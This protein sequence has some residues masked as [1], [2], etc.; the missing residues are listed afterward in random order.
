MPINNLL[1]AILETAVNQLQRLDNS[2]QEK[3]KQLQGNVIGLCLK[4][5][6]LPLYFIISEQQID[7][8]N[9]YEGEADCFISVSIKAI[10][11][12]QDNQQ[13]TTLIKSGELEVVGDIQLVQQFASLMT[14]L[15][16]DWEELLSKKV[17]DPLAHKINHHFQQITQQGCQQLAHFKKQSALYLTEEIKVA[18]SALEVAHFCDQVSDLQ[19]QSE[20]LQQ[21]VTRLTNKLLG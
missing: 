18:P 14:E 5:L 7:I 20:Q 21:K 6:D 13:T 15:D 16:I 10:D 12:L 9:Q 19:K 2:A 4:E 8:V 17:G 11:K 3:R 1:C